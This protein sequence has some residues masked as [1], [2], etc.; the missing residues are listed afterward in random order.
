MPSG[1][2][3]PPDGWQPLTASDEQLTLYDFPPR[4]TDPDELAQWNDDYSN[5]QG[6]YDDPLCT[7]AT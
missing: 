6:F 2:C 3:T 1:E 7:R 4:P 5:F